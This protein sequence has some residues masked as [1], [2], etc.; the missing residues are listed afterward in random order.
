MPADPQAALDRGWKLLTLSSQGLDDPDLEARF[1]DLLQSGGLDWADLLE[2]G[3]RH[4]TLPLLAHNIARLDGFSFVPA[5]VGHHLRDTLRLSRRKVEIYRGE[6]ARVCEALAR[7]GLR[8][9][10]TK[11]IVLESTV[12]DG[13]GDRQIG[14]MDFMVRPED[15]PEVGQAMRGLG[16]RE[17]YME[18]RTGQVKE[19]TRR[20]L[21]ARRLNPDHLPSFAKPLEDPVVPWIHADF[22]CSFTWARCPHQVPLEEA[23]TPLETVRL[24]GSGAAVPALET[25]RHF[26]FTVLHLFREAWVALWLDLEQDVDLMKFGDVLRLWRRHRDAL[27]AGEPLRRLRDWGVVEPVAW[28]LHHLDAVFGSDALD[29]LGLKDAVSRDFLFSGADKDGRLRKW[30]GDMAQRLRCRNRAELFDD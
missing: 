1:S 10:C 13:Q 24:P 8:F 20:D 4:K 30:K 25:T 9:A 11:G 29:G 23:L 7:K 5:R 21:I 17:A 19:Y 28:V 3:V 27:R 12:Y 6:A 15:G 22:A 18:N 26:L 2:Q 14:D 16:F